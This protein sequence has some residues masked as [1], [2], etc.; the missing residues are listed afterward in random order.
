MQ[1]WWRWKITYE[2]RLQA[3][4]LR[5]NGSIKRWAQTPTDLH[6]CKFQFYR[7]VN[8]K[9]GDISQL[10]YMITNALTNPASRS[11]LHSFVEVNCPSSLH[12]VG[13]SVNMPALAFVLSLVRPWI[14]TKHGSWPRECWPFLYIISSAVKHFDLTLPNIQSIAELKSD[15]ITNTNNRTHVLPRTCNMCPDLFHPECMRGLWQVC[16]LCKI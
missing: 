6:G 15:D 16:T 13:V 10:K 11:H 4:N 5:Q 8:Y 12:K 9:F 7:L 3:Q 1:D 2:T 14:Q